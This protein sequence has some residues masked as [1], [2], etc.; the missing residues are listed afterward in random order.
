MI[1]GVAAVLPKVINVL[2][3]KLHTA[4][5]STGSY[6]V[7]T[8][9]YIWA[10]Y[11]NIILTYGMETAFFRFFNKYPREQ[12][13]IIS[14]A[15][16]SIFFTG[17]LGAI[18][19]W[20]FAKELATYLNFSS[21]WH[22]KVLILISIL[23]ILVVIP[24]AYLRALGRAKKYTLYRLLNTLIYVF[25]NILFLS[26]LSQDQ[27][28]SWGL[29]FV[30]E[31]TGYIF[32]ANLIASCAVF[33]AVL[34]F[35]KFSFSLDWGILKKML[36]YG[37]PVM[38][39]GLAYCT[40]ENLDKLLLERWLGKSV[41]GMY[42]GAY[43]IG[44]FMS[45]FIMA[46]RLGAEPLFFK[47][48][49]QN[50]AKQTYAIVLKWFVIV[51]IF[52]ALLITGYIDIFANIILGSKEY[53]GALCI[54][55]IILFA[56]LFLGIY[57]TLSVWYKV[58]DATHYGMYISV[59]GAVFTALLLW[60]GIP[61]MGFMAAAWTTLCTYFLM[62]MISYLWGQKKYKVPYAVKTIVF[63]ML[64]GSVLSNVSYWFF[65]SQN[66]INTLFIIVYVLVVFVK[67]KREL[68]TFKK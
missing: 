5:L 64:L 49:A 45:L 24:F 4:V 68:Q 7:N 32:I 52:G 27:L 33:L 17:F 59:L 11:F 60:L 10:A 47:M 31:K 54:V 41:M 34:C 67:E 26:V 29:D 15:F 57:N 14:T 63:Y 36:R 9:F 35:F 48:A 16:L 20:V 28:D 50:N 38:V 51:G 37:M 21:L 55:P 19:L 18:L 25:F 22:F 13:K 8:S 65:R 62:A 61:Q 43:K 56:N 1:Y 42:A 39:A 30:T 58:T 3:V 46:F 66:A 6:S 12:K 44:V 53:Y 2:L 23:D 40:N